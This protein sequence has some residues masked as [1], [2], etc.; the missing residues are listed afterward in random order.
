MQQKMILDTI[1]YYICIY[2]TYFQVSLSYEHIYI[3]LWLFSYM[4]DIISLITYQSCHTSSNNSDFDLIG[5]GKFLHI[6]F[7]SDNAQQAF[8]ISR[9]FGMRFLREGCKILSWTFTLLLVKSNN[10]DKNELYS[11][12]DL[13]SKYNKLKLCFFVSNIIYNTL[14]LSKWYYKVLLYNII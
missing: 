6:A 11:S 1:R 13:F 9:I 4:K 3:L 12:D 5:T 7:V 8:S 10:K 2:C 14:R